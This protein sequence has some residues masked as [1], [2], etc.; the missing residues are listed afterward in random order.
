MTPL[1]NS[2]YILTII[3]VF[4]ACGSPDN[5][6][7]PTM[8]DALFQPPEIRSVM[9]DVAGY[10]FKFPSKHKSVGRD[11]PM[12]WV[13]ASFYTGVMAA[14]HATGDEIYLNAA[15]EWSEDNDWQPGPRP[16]HAD[17]HAAGQTYLD[18]YAINS[19][20]RM[21][22]PI[23]ATFDSLIAHPVMGREDWSWCDALFMAP[24]TLARLGAAT[25]DK[26]YFDFLHDMYWDTADYL[27]DRQAGLWFR[28]QS[29]FYQRTTND[30]QVYWSRGNGWVMAGIA[31][32]LPFLPEKDKK[33]DWYVQLLK[34]MAT[35]IA[36]LQGD[37]GLWR[38]SLLDADEYP[39]PETS[40]SGF[41]CFALM[42]GI[43]NG[44]LDFET[45]LPIVAKAWIGLNGA[46]HD[47]GMI[48]W[49]QPIGEGPEKVTY[50]DTQAYGAGAFLLAGSELLIHA[51]RLK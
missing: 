40:G 49:V 11:F 25:G 26:Q 43:N 35:S 8:H 32:L 12:G 24:P 23:K 22:E 18:I 16:R 4:Y 10:Q 46:I 48:G 15:I 36:P 20:P 31:R 33:R 37:D 44:Y 1:R 14:Y 50:D 29:Y 21:I 6:D 13:P 41:I 51:E 38:S 42:W 27:F 45:Y 5:S 7:A 2:I 30:K 17:D 19:E 39:A 47:N 3:G 28:D 9:A 34:T